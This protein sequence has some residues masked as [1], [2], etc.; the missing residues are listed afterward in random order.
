MNM[1]LATFTRPWRNFP[2]ILMFYAG[3]GVLGAALLT[4]LHVQFPAEVVTPPKPIP[5]ENTPDL[6]TSPPL[7]SHIEAQESKAEA[8][9]QRLLAWLEAMFRPSA[10]LK[11]ALE[12]QKAV[13]ALEAKNALELLKAEDKVY[14]L[15]LQKAE[16]ESSF[17][18]SPLSLERLEVAR[19]LEVA[20]LE[21]EEVR[22]DVA[23]NA[24]E[25]QKSEAELRRRATETGALDTLRSWVFAALVAL[26]LASMVLGALLAYRQ[27]GRRLARRFAPRRRP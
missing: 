9:P 27:I 13:D 26:G 12:L 5:I 10:E 24:M 23:E 8:A 3:F 11:L 2:R 6:R 21:L 19:R 25:L 22:R 18:A 4:F 16:L 1:T 7:I 15:E 20:Q 14:A 17:G